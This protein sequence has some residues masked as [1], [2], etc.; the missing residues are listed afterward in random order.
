MS[1]INIDEILRNHKSII[2]CFK[3]ICSKWLCNI[4]QEKSIHIEMKF[5]KNFKNNNSLNFKDILII[6]C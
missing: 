3:I 4:L 1:Y 6:F 5:K 2:I